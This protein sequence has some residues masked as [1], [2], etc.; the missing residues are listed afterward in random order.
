MKTSPPNNKISIIFALPSLCSGGAERVMS[1]IAQNIDTN[2][3][4][5]T[6]LVTGTEAQTVYDVSNVNVVY[7]N[8]SRVLNAIVPLFM[9]LRTHKPQLVISAIGHLNTLI[10]YYSIFLPKTKFIAREV[11]ILSKLEAYAFN[12]IPFSDIFSKRRFNFFDRIICQSRDMLEDLTQ[13]YKVNTNKLVVINNPITDGFTLQEKEY[14][15]GDT[16]NFVTVARLKKQ[17]GHE[18]VLQALSKVDFP[19]TYTIVGDGPE[20]ENVFNLIDTLGL[21]EKVKHIKHTNKVV[22]VLAQNDLYLQGSFIEGFPNSVIESCAAGTPIL[23]CDAPG[24]INEIIEHNIN[25]II[26]KDM[27][28]FV[29]QLNNI[30]SNYSFNRKAVSQ[31]VFDKYHKDIILKKYESVFLNLINHE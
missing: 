10:A 12:K 15:S 19:F 25:G 9:Y 30:Y 29:I 2:T 28:E 1:F 4:E 11:N 7:L 8:K 20:Y 27:D 22:D 18:R 16:L 17:K 14:H 24:G 6:I 13:N 5:P 3:F 23:A 31:C 21:T 26:A